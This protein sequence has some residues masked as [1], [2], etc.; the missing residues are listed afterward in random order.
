MY[1]YNIWY[2]KTN[3]RIECGFLSLMSSEKWKTTKQ[4]K[5]KKELIPDSG[6]EG[7]EGIEERT[8]SSSYT[9]TLQLWCDKS[10]Q[11]KQFQC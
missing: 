9:T 10:F 11:E 7:K 5:N 1:T 6:G 2:V 3:F 4:K 8:D